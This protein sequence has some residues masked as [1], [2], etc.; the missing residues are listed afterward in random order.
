MGARDD[1]ASGRR[2]LRG[3]DHACA[4]ARLSTSAGCGGR[5]LLCL[6]PSLFRGLKRPLLPCGQV[7]PAVASCSL[8]DRRQ[9]LENLLGDMS[10]RD[11][12]FGGR[13]AIRPLCHAPFGGCLGR[14]RAVLSVIGFRKAPQ[15]GRSR[16]RGAGGLGSHLPGSP[17]SEPH[18]EPL[19]TLFRLNFCVN[20]PVGH[21][22]AKVGRE[23]SAATTV[24][25]RVPPTT[26][27][28]RGASQQR[29][30]HGGLG[31]DNITSN[32]P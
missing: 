23:D 13:P 18:F 19:N 6:F 26:H 30:R 20:G 22:D 27:P 9:L 5:F 29:N 8:W 32:Q 21:G 11:T 16:P 28:R 14:G 12:A 31:C 25:Q 24:P 10:Q 1:P 17:C 4:G 7:G 2:G 3:R 15:K